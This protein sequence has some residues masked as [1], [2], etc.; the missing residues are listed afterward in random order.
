MIND[1]N[2]FTEENKNN[3]IRSVSNSIS[4]SRVQ[5]VSVFNNNRLLSVL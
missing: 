4:Q 5:S 3:N 2:Q 1:W